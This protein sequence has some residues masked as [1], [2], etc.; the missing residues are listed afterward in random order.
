MEKV[1]ENKARLCLFASSWPPRSKLLVSAGVLSMPC[2]WKARRGLGAFVK[3]L[4]ERRRT[5]LAQLLD[6]VWLQWWESHLPFWV[7]PKHGVPQSHSSG[8]SQEGGMEELPR[9]NLGCSW[10]TRPHMLKTL[11]GMGLSPWA[12]YTLLDLLALPSFWELFRFHFFGL[13]FLVR[14]SLSTR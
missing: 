12:R 2:L 8:Q 11:T 5:A 4:E 1:L 13:W 3:N 10:M 14:L 9:Q 7:N 6:R